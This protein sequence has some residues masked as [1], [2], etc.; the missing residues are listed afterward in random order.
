MTKASRDTPQR[1]PNLSKLGIAILEHLV[2]STLGEAAIEEVYK[3]MKILREEIIDGEELLLVK[4]YM[5]GI[6]LG[7]VDGP[8]HVISRWKSLIL[9]DLDENYFY[10]SMNTIKNI[11]APELKELSNKYLLP[12][13]FFELVVI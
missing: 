6:N 4:N 2:E 3:E 13:E 11:S 12:E 8:F 10:D 5:M 9:N 1:F 7:D